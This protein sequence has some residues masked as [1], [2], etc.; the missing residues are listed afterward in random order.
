M[1]SGLEEDISQ[2]T[3]LV[4]YEQGIGDTLQMLRFV[5]A[6]AERAARIRLVVQR[7]LLDFVQ[8]NLDRFAEVTVRDVNS[9]NC[10]RYVR[11]MSLPALI[12]AL[13]QF[14]P[15]R[16]PQ[17]TQLESL[18]AKLGI[19]WAGNPQCRDDNRRSMPISE[20]KPLFDRYNVE[21]HNL[22]VGSRAMDAQTWPQLRPPDPPLR[23][24]ADTAN[25]MA[26]LDCVITVD[27]AVA[28]LAG[29]L[30]IPTFLLLPAAASW[31]WGLNDTTPWYP[32]MR[33]IRQQT[34]GDWRSAT[35]RLMLHLDA[36]L[37]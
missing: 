12:G 18:S 20:L 16:A 34:G 10:D 19:C 15:F 5:P 13:P 6:I 30:G 32:S 27:T 7:A 37:K 11:I 14:I 2:Q 23:S 8:Y 36:M 26:G 1:W 4:V 25:L 33:L 24:F 17:A 21:W 9:M 3:L 29:G 28:H 35:E 31:R 22:Y